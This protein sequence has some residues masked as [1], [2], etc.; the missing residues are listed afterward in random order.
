M[1]VATATTVGRMK[2]TRPTAATTAV[3]RATDTASM[4]GT[5]SDAAIA[6]PGAQ[7]KVAKKPKDGQVSMAGGEATVEVAPM[8]S[9]YGHNMKQWA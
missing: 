7:A 6:L 4:A 2:Y 3:V 9:C 1:A 5:A 8:S